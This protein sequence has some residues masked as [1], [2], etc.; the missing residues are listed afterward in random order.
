M[1]S[2][3]ASLAVLFLVVATLSACSSEFSPSELSK[4]VK[5]ANK[6]K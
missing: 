2:I 4:M 5:S 6:K 3:L 1:R